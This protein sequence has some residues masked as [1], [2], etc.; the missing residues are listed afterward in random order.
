MNYD[1]LPGLLL[2]ALLSACGPTRIGVPATDS[3]TGESTTTGE[4]TGA[5]FNPF[6]VPSLGGCD[7]YSQDCPEG[8]KCVPYAS[9]G[10]TWDANK[11]VPVLGD[12]ALGE[13]CT[14]DGAVEATDDCDASSYCW[15]V[16]GEGVGTCHAFCMG[17]PDAP[18][19]PPDSRCLLSG[20]GIPN[21]CYPACDPLTQDCGPGLACYWVASYFT[22][23]FTTQDIPTGEPCGF[24]NDCAPGNICESAEVM[25]D[26]EGVACCAAYCNINLDDAQCDAV[27]GTVCVPFFKESAPEAYEHLGVCVAPPGEP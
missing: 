12:G 19:C 14:Y 13:T 20:S 26:C 7:P 24:I 1:N 17:S 3:E 27:P 21:L 22:C 16:D 23:A 15:K 5:S 6:D 25:P 18:V 8:E 9:S 4:S 2:A 10:G 11:C